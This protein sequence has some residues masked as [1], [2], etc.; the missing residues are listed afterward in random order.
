MAKSCSGNLD[1]DKV[2]VT[3]NNSKSLLVQRGFGENYKKYLVLDMYETLYLLEN[4]SLT[5]KCKGRKISAEKLIDKVLK[6]DAKKY[7]LHR[8]EVY[9]DIKSKGYV[10]KTG[11]K[12]GFDFRVYPKGKKISEE[13]TQFVVGVLPE[14]QTIKSEELAKSVRMASTLHTDLILAIV[15]NELE[16]SYYKISREKF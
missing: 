2:I 14:T 12:F 9:N 16:I 3:D 7:F 4:N 1:G 11:L 13:H 10:I 5:V 8:Y 6:E 15:D